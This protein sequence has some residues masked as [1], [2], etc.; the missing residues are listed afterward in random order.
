MGAVDIRGPL[1]MEGASQVVAD[2][3]AAA[4]SERR[5]PAHEAS[6]ID[7]APRQLA[8]Q[9]NA[10]D[11]RAYGPATQ[12]CRRRPTMPAATNGAPPTR[13]GSRAGIDMKRILILARCSSLAGGGAAGRLLPDRVS[14]DR[15]R[16]SRRTPRARGAARYVFHELPVGKTLM[17]L[18][19]VRGPQTSLRSRRTRRIRPTKVVAIGNL[20]MQGGSTQAG[21]TIA[22]AG[23]P[24]P[25]RPR[26]RR[27]CDSDPKSARGSPDAGAMQD[28]SGRTRDGDP[29]SSA[30]RVARPGDAA[31]RCPADD[32]P[33]NAAPRF[34][35]P[36]AACL[37]RTDAR[38]SPS[39]RSRREPPRSR[40][41]A[42]RAA[43]Y[44]WRGPS[45]PRRPRG[46]P[47]RASGG[48][49]SSAR[50]PPRWPRA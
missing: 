14:P 4:G 9:G 13:R 25:A 42:E 45:P 48:R 10:R 39:I 1:A 5:R 47:R 35:L 23:K 29:P 49:G 30:A 24:E 19:A 46:S 20:A 6:R 40:G 41:C 7:G 50:A 36:Y 44:V 18:R 22:N 27:G 15:E 43:R 16:C 31:R 37:V 21:P 28:R 17:S 11:L 26:A 34:S 8:V 12:R 2:R 32:E 3:N 38:P 33:A